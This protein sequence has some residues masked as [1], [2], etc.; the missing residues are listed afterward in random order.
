MEQNSMS[1]SIKLG[2]VFLPCNGVRH[3]QFGLLFVYLDL[4]YMQIIMVGYI[5]VGLF[6]YYLECATTSG[7]AY[8]T[9]IV[10]LLHDFITLL[11]A[12]FYLH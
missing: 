10:V 12:W 7:E 3:H 9:V 6:G 2:G 1:C 5:S 11:C 8:P 4:G